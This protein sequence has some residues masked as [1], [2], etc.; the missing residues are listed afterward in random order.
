MDF[1]GDLALMFGE[2]GVSVDVAG[3]QHVGLIDDAYAEQ[4]GIGGSQ[5]V[6]I[7]QTAAGI[8][9]GAALTVQ[10]VD[11]TVRAVQPDGAGLTRLLLERA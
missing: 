1:A 8:A 2:F 9:H 6:L 4:I 11:Y 7:V 3:V 5:P 10:G